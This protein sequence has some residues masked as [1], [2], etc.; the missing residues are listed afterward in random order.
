M[1][2]TSYETAY[3]TNYMYWYNRMAKLRKSAPGT[4]R[5]A[6]AEGA[7]NTFC[8]EA[9]K[10]KKVVASGEADDH[11]FETWMLMQRDVIDALMES[12]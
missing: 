2:Q 6:D 5:L 3:K 7:F 9:V 8:N 1:K 4:D 12:G 10:R 11:E